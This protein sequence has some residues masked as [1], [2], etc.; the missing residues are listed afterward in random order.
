M[1]TNTFLRRLTIL[2]FKKANE[3]VY[4]TVVINQNH[5]ISI[6]LR[7]VY[8]DLTSPLLHAP[9]VTVTCNTSTNEYISAGHR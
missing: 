6:D 3:S 9:L 8:L 7:Y 5:L 1:L 2:N 4:L